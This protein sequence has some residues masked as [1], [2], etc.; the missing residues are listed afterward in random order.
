M[1]LLKTSQ[2]VSTDLENVYKFFTEPENLA[3]ITPGWLGFHIL[4]PSPVAMRVGAIIDYEIK[5]G[6]LP[7]RWRSIITAYDQG[8][9]FVDEQLNGPYSFWHHTHRFEVTEQGTTIHDEVRYIPPF[10][11]L[12]RIANALAIKNQL[13]GIFAHRHRVIAEKFGGSLEDCQGPTL[14]CLK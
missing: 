12:G 5:L 7:T 4:T 1:Y 2:T 6:P 8:R 11:I 10:G 14:T 13:R 3:T 9:L